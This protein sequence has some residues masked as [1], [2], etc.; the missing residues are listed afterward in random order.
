MQF[1]STMVAVVMA[2]ILADAAHALPIRI[3][4]AYPENS[5]QVQI[6]RETAKQ[7]AQ[8]TPTHVELKFF[9]SG[10]MGNDVEVLRKIDAGELD[11]GMITGG[12][13]G[14]AMADTLAYALPFRLASIE[15]VDFVRLKMDASIVDGIEKQS[16]LRVLGMAEGGFAYVFSMKRILSMDALISQ[17]M[18]M[19]E[20]RRA[21]DTLT[22]LGATTLVPLP[23][24][25]VRDALRAH[26]IDTVVVSPFG[27]V[28]SQWHTEINY[29]LN[30]PL[31]YAL[32]FLV[33]DKKVLDNMPE[34]DS[35][36]LHEALKAALVRIGAHNRSANAEAAGVLASDNIQ[37]TSVDPSLAAA[38]QA[39]SQEA[40]ERLIAQ[41]ALSK[42][43]V[44]ELDTYIGDFRKKSK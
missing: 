36:V 2:V 41:G 38:F 14:G 15:E 19:P 33:V 1:K 44:Q 26:K 30:I 25:E 34:D 43:V 32:S 40:T 12:G 8:Q 24:G 18:W 27:A 11:G 35:K 13:I 31:M 37:D 5:K 6:L 22:A 28:A 23:L 20:N 9:T 16:N 4:T 7:I 39:A 42:T 21:A 3:A 29:R 10:S 17:R